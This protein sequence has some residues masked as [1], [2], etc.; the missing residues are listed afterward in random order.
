MTD[1]HSIRN[2][3]ISQRPRRT[4]RRY[5]WKSGTHETVATGQTH[6]INRL[7]FAMPIEVYEKVAGEIPAYAGLIICERRDWLQRVTPQKIKE[8]PA[9]PLSRKY[10]PEHRQKALESVY[11]R[12]WHLKETEMEATS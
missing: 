3:A 1:V 7:W 9:L 6:L 8:A 4:V 2:L 10:E 5:D 12:F 11:Y